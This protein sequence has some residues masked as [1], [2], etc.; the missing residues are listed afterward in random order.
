MDYFPTPLHLV[1][2]FHS[3]L[4]NHKMSPA[5]SNKNKYGDMM[6]KSQK[7]LNTQKRTKKAAAES[8]AGKQ[9]TAELPINNL[10][11]FHQ[12]PI[13]DRRLIQDLIL[14]RKYKTSPNKSLTKDF[15]SRVERKAEGTVGKKSLPSYWTLFSKDDGGVEKGGMYI[16]RGCFRDFF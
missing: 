10:K 13:Y 9:A 5:A 3:L 4:I 1:V 15:G 6:P 7:K 14:W 12:C 8:L 2:V 16:I 11:V